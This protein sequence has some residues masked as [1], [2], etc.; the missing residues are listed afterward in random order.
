MF[1]WNI[2]QEGIK[3]KLSILSRYLLS[4]IQMIPIYNYYGMYN[5]Y[6]K[7]LT[8]SLLKIIFHML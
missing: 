1:F 4:Y 8:D 3:H 2:L 6:T 7:G 5:L